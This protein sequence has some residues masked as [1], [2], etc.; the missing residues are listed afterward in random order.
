MNEWNI[1]DRCEIVNEW[2]IVDRWKIVNEWEIVNE[3]NKVNIM[4]QRDG[5][6][7]ILDRLIKISRMGGYIDSFGRVGGNSKCFGRMDGNIDNFERIGG[8]I[9]SFRRMN[10]INRTGIMSRMSRIN[11]TDGGIRMKLPGLQNTRRVLAASLCGVMLL[12]SESAMAETVRHEHVFA[13]T[14]SEGNVSS[15]TDSIRLENQDKVDEITTLTMLSD[16]ENVSGHETFTQG[17]GTITWKTGGHDLIYQGTSDQPLPFVPTVS[18]TMNGK[19]ATAE[20]IRA[21]QGEVTLTVTYESVVGEKAGTISTETDEFDPGETTVPYLALTVILLPGEGVGEI[22]S[23]NAAVLTLS[24]Q[25]AVAGWGI[26]GACDQLNLPSSFSVTFEA[27]HALP[28]WMVTVASADPV[29]LA[30]QEVQK[31]FLEKAGLDREGLHAELEDVVSALDALV[32]EHPLPELT[33]RMN[34]LAV[35]TN[36]FNNG[37][38]RINEGASA[39]KEGASELSEGAA[40]ASEN[41]VLAAAGASDLYDGSLQLSQG[42]DALSGGLATLKENSDG[43]NSGA[44]DIFSSIL[45]TANEQ[46]ADSGLAEAGIEMPELTKDNFAEVLTETIEKLDPEI[47]EDKA[48]KEVELLIRMKLK[49]QGS[50]IR[51]QVEDAVTSGVLDQILRQE[52]MEM[53]AAGWQEAVDSGVVSEETVNR[54]QSVLEEQLA[55][56]AVQ[57]Q[58]E[59]QTASTTEELL[60]KQVEDTL[61]NDE[62]VKEKLARAQEGRASLQVLLGKLTGMQKFIE[63]LKA[64]TDGVDSAADGAAKVKDGAAA[65]KDGA[66]TLSDGAAALSDGLIQ[67]SDGAKELSDGSDSLYTEGTSVLYDSIKNVE[68]EAAQKLLTYIN[69]DAKTILSLFENTVDSAGNGGYDLRDD[70]MKTVT[71]YIIRTDL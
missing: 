41:M 33:G 52:G 22:R 53:D 8:N 45:E 70:S 25:Q 34:D 27:D 21:G 16:I 7:R 55:S 40:S 11:R 38:S 61:A 10:R 46:L 24:G 31:M 64:Y 42:T 56:D 65:L 57:E 19:E 17:E 9:D 49:L 51:S 20:E 2:N 66:K 63:G 35:K 68:K 18:L 62:T 43:L 3:R 28:S 23:E 67:L 12:G 5:M 4:E 50:E 44:Q 32:S 14:D 30:G 69:E 47:L 36:E 37:I 39:L 26:P 71:A 29:D 15:L 48:R 59:Q 60:Q 6:S 13:V 54:I 58:I 1:V